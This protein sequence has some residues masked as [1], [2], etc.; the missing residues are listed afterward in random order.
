[1]SKTKTKKQKR[2]LRS[3]LKIKETEQKSFY[4]L[5]FAIAVLAV[6]VIICLTAFLRN[7]VGVIHLSTT[8]EGSNVVDRR[9][10][11]T[12]E[13]APMSYSVDIDRKEVYA[14]YKDTEFYKVLGVD[15]DRMLA[16]ETMGV[17]DVY[18]NT[19]Y[20]LPSFEDFKADKAL[21]CAVEKIS[22][23]IGAM[24]PEQSQLAADLLLNGERCDYPNAINNNSV[25]H[26]YFGSTENPYVY[27]SVRYFED[28]AGQ[29]YLYDRDLSVCVNIGSELKE[30]LN[31]N[32]QS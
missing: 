9:N 22:Y 25:L 17:I 6:A 16:T 15:T 5:L 23:A 1:M 27:Y 26:I 20:P 31:N 4:L 24:S 10:G 7:Y 11:I 30:V 28:S 2:T 32:V 12:Y 8:M 21:I 18:Y 19:E 13:L 14:K 3:I 29:R